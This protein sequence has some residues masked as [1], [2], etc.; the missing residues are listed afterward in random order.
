MSGLDKPVAAGTRF[1]KAKPSSIAVGGD[2]AAAAAAAAGDEG[3]AADGDAEPASP[4]S[5]GADAA[6]SDADRVAYATML[7]EMQTMKAELERLRQAQLVPQPQPQSLSLGSPA[8]PPQGDPQQAPISS[9]FAMLIRAMQSSQADLLRQQAAAQADQMRQQAAQQNLLQ[10]LGDLPAFSGKGADTT[11]TAHDWLRRADRFFSTREQATG[12][13]GTP[14][15]DQARLLAAANAL[16]D[17]AER[18]YNALPQQPST[19]KEFGDAVRARFCSVPSERIRVDK[20]HEFVEKAARLRDKLNVQGMQAFTAQFAQLAG[21]VPADLAPP[22]VL[23]G[24][25]ARCLPQRYAEVV[26]KEDAKKPTPALHD[27]INTVLSRAANKEQAASFGGASASSGSAPAAVDAISL[28]SATFGWSRE[29]AVQNLA[30]SEGWAEHD[31]SGG[32]QRQVP[33]RAPAF[34]ASSRM[35]DDQFAQILNAVAAAARI[36]AGPAA[37]ERNSSRRHVPSGIW[38]EVPKELAEARKAAGLCIKCGVQ[39]YEGG[40]HGHNAVT[41]KQPADKTTTVAEGKKKA[42]F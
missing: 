25:L 28:A 12:I 7:Q 37:R 21:E 20:L 23:L 22:R 40:A 33:Q 19:W 1:A 11:L 30:E 15:A 16:T 31:T 39:K 14:E 35:A 32:Q 34:A 13:S 24:M 5:Q 26:M 8:A 4:Q 6:S 38:N 9:E 41:C 18:W 29:E 36:G 17:N 42:G 27:V 3:K 10:S 2:D